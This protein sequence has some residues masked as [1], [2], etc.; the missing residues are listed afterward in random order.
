MVSIL[1]VL[2]TVHSEEMRKDFNYSLE[3]MGEIIEWFKPDI[4]CGEVRP[5]DWQ[6][7]CDNNEYE[8]YLGPNEYRRLIIP[9]CEK[10]NIKFIP[11]DWYEDD[12][13]NM[14]YFQGKSD[15][16]VNDLEKQFESIMVDYMDVAKK[17]IIP[18]NSLDFNNIVEKKQDFQNS[19]NPYVHNV[20]WTCRNQI[21][22][23]RVKKALDINKGKKVLCTV[24]AEHTYFYYRNLKETNREII[25]PLK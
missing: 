23:E 10:N 17:S 11:I 3:K 20:Y 13:I 12:L 15:L 22:V 5:E 4:I 8:G 19:I 9:L 7:H 24:G 1:G 21:M 25:Y 2:G 16:E 18:F 6:K 14:D